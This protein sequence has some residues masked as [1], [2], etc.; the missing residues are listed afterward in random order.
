MIEPGEQ[1]SLETGGY[2][3]WIF[4][5]NDHDHGPAELE[6]EHPHK[7]DVEAGIRELKSNFGLGTIRKHGFMA[8]WAWLLMLCLG[9]NIS[10]W[11]QQLGRLPSGR[12]GSE[13]RAKRFRYH[14]LAIPALLVRSGRRLAIK[15]PVTYRSR[16]VFGQMIM[17]DRWVRGRVVLGTVPQNES[18]TIT[19]NIA[20]FDVAAASKI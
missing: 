1:A 8:N 2:R 11:V 17:P 3:Y 19:G 20:V 7:A 14:F 5:T 4:V 15:L 13:L 16:L 6:S 9:H 18:D 10:R 12:D